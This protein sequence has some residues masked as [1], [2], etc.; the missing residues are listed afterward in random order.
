MVYKNYIVL[1]NV[2]M[3]IILAFLITIRM[4]H[5]T[6]ENLKTRKIFTF[7][8]FRFYEQFEISGCVELSIKKEFIPSGLDY[9]LAK[10]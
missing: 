4:I 10:G 2:K 7:Q 9:G 3:P 6:S 1:I 5:T 8:H